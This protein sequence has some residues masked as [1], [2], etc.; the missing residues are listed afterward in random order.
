MWVSFWIFVKWPY[1]KIMQELNSIWFLFFF[2]WLLMFGS[3]KL[4]AL[5][6]LQ[7]LI[8]F[9]IISNGII[10][11]HWFIPNKALIKSNNLQY[12]FFFIWQHESNTWTLHI[13]ASSF[14][15][16]TIGFTSLNKITNHKVKIIETFHITQ[17]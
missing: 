9:I 5:A 4:D 10:L 15:F 11:L 1:R 3:K 17:V 12:F 16:W 2:L 6:T 7:Y 14:I 13:L 8:P